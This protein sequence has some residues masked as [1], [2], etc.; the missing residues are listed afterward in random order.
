MALLEAQDLVCVRGERTVF[1]GL[2]LAL[3][4][5]EAVLLSGPNGS[6]KSSLLRLLAGLLRPAAGRILWQQEPI[7]DDPAAHRARLAYVG[8]QDPVKPVLSVR[9]NLAFWTRLKG[10]A[11][12]AVPAA[13]EYLGLGN[14][15]AVPGGMLSAGQRRRL[16]LARLIAAPATLWLLDEPTVGLDHDSVAIL[17]TMLAAHQSAGGL[18]L[19]ATHLPLA[20]AGARELALPCEPGADAAP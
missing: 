2:D 7:G 17:E 6:G 15:A 19:L 11:A 13:L 18:L 5:G 3:E 10:G 16:N 14:L 4:P 12:S 9:E 20:L 8:H 1:A